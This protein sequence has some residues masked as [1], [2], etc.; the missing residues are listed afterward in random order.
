MVQLRSGKIYVEL[1]H[2]QSCHVF[3]NI[4]NARLGRVWLRMTLLTINVEREIYVCRAG[5]LS[6]QS[7]VPKRGQTEVLELLH[8]GHSGKSLD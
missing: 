4:Y 6:E 7:I 3:T 5:A 8:D 1:N 2:I